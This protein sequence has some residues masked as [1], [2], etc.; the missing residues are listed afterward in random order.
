M[1]A[2]TF[3]LVGCVILL[4]AG[5]Y[6]VYLA[7]TIGNYWMTTQGTKS[8]PSQCLQTDSPFYIMNGQSFTGPG[9]SPEGKFNINTL[10]SSLTIDDKQHLIMV[11]VDQQQT[12][13][14]YKE[15]KIFIS[16]PAN[17]LL[18]SP[19]YYF[20]VLTQNMKT[21]QLIS[22]SSKAGNYSICAY[23][24]SPGSPLQY[25]IYS[26]DNNLNLIPNT[27]QNFVS[28][29][30]LSFIVSIVVGVLWIIALIQFISKHS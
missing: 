26:L 3:F 24:Y 23:Q 4:I 12:E 22:D 14:T 11:D 19:T 25:G 15:N 27:G 29:V 2:L 17:S 30:L 21:I 10:L 18:G 13:F 28:I 9:P 7:K 16:P 5:A 1:S 20:P 6:M 8:L